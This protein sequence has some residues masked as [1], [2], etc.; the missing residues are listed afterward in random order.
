MRHFPTT[1][2]TLQRA[3]LT[4]G[5]CVG[6]GGRGGSIEEMEGSQEGTQTDQRTKCI[7]NVSDGITERAG[8]TV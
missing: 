2:G 1:H 7:T 8:E 4:P 6:G 3:N 5:K